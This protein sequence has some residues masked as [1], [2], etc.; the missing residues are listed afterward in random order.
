MTRVP[1][2]AGGCGKDV[3][4]NANGTWRE[5]CRAC[6]GRQKGKAFTPTLRAAAERYR[7]RVIEER[8]A[9]AREV[10]QAVAQRQVTVEAALDVIVT[11]ER[12]AYVRGYKN[13]HIKMQSRRKTAA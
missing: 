11:L 9:R 3:R 12:E 10:L 4:Q 2:C 8:H 13:A 6:N 7:L 5:R 1:K